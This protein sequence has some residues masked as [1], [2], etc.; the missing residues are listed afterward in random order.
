MK[1]FAE[2]VGFDNSDEPD[3]ITESKYKINHRSY[4][5]AVQEIEPFAYRNGYVMDSEELAD[6]IGLGPSK[7]KNGKTNKFHFKLYE[8]IIGED[9]PQLARKM[10]HVQIYGDEGRYEL[11]M[12]IN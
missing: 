10:L 1:T 7:P 3:N 4:T 9:E 11:N 2:Y 8:V 5:S 6:E 12:Y